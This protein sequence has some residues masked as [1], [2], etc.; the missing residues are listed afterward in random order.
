MNE[1]MPPSHMPAQ[2]ENGAR[3]NPASGPA[4]ER[5]GR[6]LWLTARSRFS[7]IGAALGFMVML[8]VGL[9]TLATLALQTLFGEG[10][11]TWA[12]LLASSVPLYAVAMP[13]SMLVFRLV[14]AVETRRYPMRAG[15]FLTLL[16]MCV[17]VMY[18]G[19]IIG[20]M[21]SAGITG[22]QATNRVSDLMLG[23]DWW[24]NALFVGLLAPICEEWL[25]R[26]EIISR[27]R[28][29]GEKT[30][31]VFSA[32]AFALFHMNMFQFFYAF[33]LGLILGYVYTRTSRLRYSVIMHA[34]INLNGGVIAPLVM[35][36]VDSRLL[37]G[38]ISDAEII[39]MAQSG[40]TGGMGVMM[41]YGIVMLG[42]LI[43]GIVLLIVKRRSWEFYTAPEELMA[44]TKLRA[45]Y[46]NPGVLFY[47]LLAVAL[48]AYMLLVQ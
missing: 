4:P 21:L 42:L 25:F 32:I 15:E 7:I 28:R 48:T 9:N 35:Q 26:K 23:G 3:P 13:L 5:S 2:P 17:P 30:A 1:M 36:Q 22:G 45:A 19:N 16:I 12:V 44:G 29:Y 31:I 46:V 43:A 18:G 41:L 27:L 39:R 33:G 11:P 40:D 37:D 38:S 6:G 10:V 34:V 47:I 20:M 24:V 14:P 8:W